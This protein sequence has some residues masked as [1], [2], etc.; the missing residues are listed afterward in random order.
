MQQTHSTQ[1]TLYT[2]LTF[3]GAIPFV[4]A[5]ILLMMG[6]FELPYLGTISM[7]LASYGLAI[8]TFVAGSQWGLYKLSKQRPLPNFFILSNGITVTAISGFILLP[9]AYFLLVLVVLY[10]MLLWLEKDFYRVGVISLHY[11]TV[12]VL[13]TALVVCSLLLSV[14]MVM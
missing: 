2:A 13:V 9:T 5:V 8:V 12:R 4:G 14:M 6:R 11:L 1:V 7:A 10:L 3:A